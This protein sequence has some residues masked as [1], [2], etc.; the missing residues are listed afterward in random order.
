M[1]LNVVGSFNLLNINIGLAAALGF[2]NP[3]ALQLDLMLTGMFGLGPFLASLQ[4]QFSA[5]IS[6]ALNIGL[7]IGNP[8]VA[9]QAL[10]TAFA[11]LQAALQAV[12]AIGLPSVQ[13]T[14]GL[15]LSAVASLIATLQ[16][17]IGGIK[18]MIAAA[19][20]IKIPA[21]QFIAELAANLNLG[22]VWLIS[23]TGDSLATTG[24][25]IS[26]QFT[27]GL[28]PPDQIFPADLVSGVLLVTK[29]PS[30]YAG[31]QAIIKTS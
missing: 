28:G 17:Q 8:L 29:N 25:D 20:A 27:A 9:I 21:V 24:T 23:F 19:L 14:L 5:A 16:L 2:L 26:T 7:Q 15:Q 3:L 18:A 1:A 22:P 10:I 30:A 13:L 4:A 31:I 6:A 12:L 11:Q